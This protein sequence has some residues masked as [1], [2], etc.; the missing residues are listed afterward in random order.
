M[1]R[2]ALILVASWWLLASAQ[3]ETAYVTD[4]LQLNMYV[5]VEMTGSPILKLRSGDKMEIIQRKGRYALVESSGGKKGWV[6]SLYL[7]DREPARTRVN[8]LEHSNQ[9]L[10]GTVK[11]LRSQLSVEQG[12]LKELKE[13]QSGEVDQLAARET[14][15]EELRSKNNQ[16]KNS[17]EAYA[18]SVPVTWLLIVFIITLVGGLGGGWYLVDKRSRD[19]HGGFRIY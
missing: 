10:E 12:K 13:A 18:M 4:M 19:R 2:Y 1:K 14:E 7:V 17:L 8:Q 11:K 9:G 3:A 15:L 5:T 6:K 16:L